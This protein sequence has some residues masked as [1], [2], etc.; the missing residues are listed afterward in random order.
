[1]SE[2]HTSISSRADEGR[3]T[4]VG[5]GFCNYKPVDRHLMRVEDGLPLDFAVTQLN[6]LLDCLQEMAGDGVVNS[7]ISERQAWLMDFC[8]DV[9]MGLGHTIE[10]SLMKA[11]RDLGL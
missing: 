5:Q 1:M 8:L 4:T 3:F 9:A 2:Q 7:G 11:E 10:S 6:C